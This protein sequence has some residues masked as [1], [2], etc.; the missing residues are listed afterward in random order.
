V[1]SNLVANNPAPPMTNAPAILMGAYS[2]GVALLYPAWASNGILQFSS[3]LAPLS[4]TALS[5]TSSVM[6]NYNVV[7]QPATNGAG[8]FRLSH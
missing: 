4:W 2:G 1:V 8:F 6:S 7:A 5:V 3:N